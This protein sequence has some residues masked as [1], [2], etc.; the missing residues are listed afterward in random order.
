MATN[1]TSSPPKEK[2]NFPPKR[3]KIKA[4]I[5]SSLVKFVAST[6]LPNTGK[7]KENGDGSASSTPPPSAY[8]S[9]LS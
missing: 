3:G 5:F 6:V 8:N 4:Q 9:D 1:G 2:A 7:V